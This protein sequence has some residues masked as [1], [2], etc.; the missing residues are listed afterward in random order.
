MHYEKHGSCATEQPTAT[1][2]RTLVGTKNYFE[3]TFYMCA[4]LD[5]KKALDD[6]EFKPKDPPFYHDIND[7]F[8]ELMRLYAYKPY[9][10]CFN[11]SS[12]DSI[13]ENISFCYDK[14]LKLMDCSQQP[15]Q[16]NE[17]FIIPTSVF[18]IE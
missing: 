5:L 17:K 14:Q 3:T 11:L 18:Q 10:K 16:C 2:K 6:T 13:I 1:E 12:N 4:I 9:I 15:P 7:F 8:L